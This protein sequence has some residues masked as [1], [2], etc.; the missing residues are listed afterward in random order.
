MYNMVHCFLQHQ[1][2][3]VYDVQSRQHIGSIAIPAHVRRPD[4]Y[5]CHLCWMRGDTLLIGWGRRICMTHVKERSR[6]DLTVAS[7]SVRYLETS[8][9]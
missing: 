1:G 3:H 9:R 5:K 2:T 6:L 4:I 8:V 7:A